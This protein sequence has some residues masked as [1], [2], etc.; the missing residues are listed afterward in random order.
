MYRA[1]ERL[2]KLL[3]AVNQVT[4]ANDTTLTAAI[5]RLIAGYKGGET[6]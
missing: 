1:K 2:L 3:E 6:T 5:A 4:G